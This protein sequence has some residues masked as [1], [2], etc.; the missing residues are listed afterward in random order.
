MTSPQADRVFQAL[1]DPTRRQLVE[2]LSAAEHSTPTE[3]AGRL[4]ITR[5][6]I[7]KHLEV[8]ETAGLVK[9][10]QVGRQRRYTFTPRPLEEPL[11]WIES[12]ASRWDRRLERLRRYLLEELESPDDPGQ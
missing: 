4:P 5:Q 8:L 1:A 7:S 12:I 11:V 6:G 9:S 3:L 2:L 10:E